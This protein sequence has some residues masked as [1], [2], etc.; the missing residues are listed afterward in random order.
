MAGFNDLIISDIRD[1]PGKQ[2][3]AVNIPGDKN[4]KLFQSGVDYFG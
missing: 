1:R 3:V 4:Q 2:H